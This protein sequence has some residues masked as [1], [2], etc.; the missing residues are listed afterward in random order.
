LGLKVWK[1][2]GE[3]S[4]SQGKYVV[5]SKWIYKIKHD[6][7]VS[8]DKYKARFVDRGFSRKEGEYYD[9]TFVIVARYTYIIAIISLVASMGWSLH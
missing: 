5:T 7:D 8:I 9:E 2:P 1:K 6:V 3:V 4:L